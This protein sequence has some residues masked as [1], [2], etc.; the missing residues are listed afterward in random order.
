MKSFTLQRDSEHS[1]LSE[2]WKHGVMQPDFLEVVPARTPNAN[3]SV[4]LVTKELQYKKKPLLY[5]DSKGAFVDTSLFSELKTISVVQ[6]A[7]QRHAVIGSTH[8]DIPWDTLVRFLLLS[9]VICT[10]IHIGS[11]MKV[12]FPSAHR[13]EV[14]GSHTYYTNEENV[15]DFS[16]SIEQDHTRTIHCLS[17]SS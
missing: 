13:A 2:L 12:D 14:R 1:L 15:E 16:F 5:I 11:K 3:A 6:L 17:L 4:A 10:Y 7:T 9:D 8:Q